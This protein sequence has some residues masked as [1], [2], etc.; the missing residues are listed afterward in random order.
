MQQSKPFGAWAS[1]ISAK[2][3]TSAGL[4]LGDVKSVDGAVFWAEVRP[5][6]K[7]RCVI[8]K[9]AAGQKPVD[10]FASPFNV[11][12]RVH[13]Y[14]GG[15][16][17]VDQQFLYFVHWDDQ[18]LYRVSHENQNEQPV[19]LTI[20]PET[21]Q[22]LRYADGCLSADGAWIVCVRE[23]HIDSQSHPNNELVAIPNATDVGN[24]SGDTGDSAII[25]AS[26]EDFY[27]TPRISPD[28]KRLSWI[29]WSHPQMPWDG[30]EL[31]V[32]DIHD[33]NELHDVSTS[34]KAVSGGAD[35]SVMGAM[36][37][38]N[39][40]LL[41]ASDESGWWN[42]YAY[43]VG[44]KPRQLTSFTDREVGTPAWVFGTQR[45]VLIGGQATQSSHRLALAVTHNARDE[46]MLL[47]ADEKL[48]KIELPYS[49]ISSIAADEHGALL[50]S[51]QPETKQASIMRIDIATDESCSDFKT[52]RSVE[53]LSIHADWIS[54]AQAITFPSS[55]K[56][57][58]AF[59]YPPTGH[60]VNGSDQE[61]PP[62][63]VMSHGGPTSHANSGLKL[64]VQYWTSRGIAVVDV[65]YGGSSGFGRDYRRRLQG[66]WSV[67]DVEDCI[68]AAN[69]LAEQ[70]MVDASRMVIRGGSAGGL[71]VLRAM[72]TSSSFAAGA[73]FYGVADLELLAG[74]THKFESRY[75]D[76]LL[77]GP[78][79]E[80]KSIYQERSP[81][82]HTDKLNCPILVM[83][84]DE[85]K[86]VPPNQ[87]ET[88]VNAAAEKGLPHAYIVFTGE[89]HGFRQPKNII[90]ALQI[91]LWFYSKVLGFNT[92]EKIAA[93]SE[94]IGL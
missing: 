61:L 11:R 86:V 78:Y 38:S 43:T 21:K 58:H 94:A 1:P 53:P 37:A 17:W 9:A 23:R 40:E 66:Q 42:V 85:D 26:G 2:L 80:C 46:L 54:V 83:Q 48:S 79:P 51:G 63:I 93:P 13:E 91:E 35:I 59:F 39:G 15:A 24:D 33:L 20:E 68:A 65:N 90:R 49:T 28:G 10:L 62:L 84:G 30:T 5:A 64:S 14:G 27:S 25:L 77:G 6:D 34:A 70:K 89:Q 41:F 12:T 87:S 45:F 18:R 3:V 4:K 72:Q 16:W 31:M 67:V 55:D 73:S 32:A 44:E 22:A 71:T 81:I 36:W 75:L 52:L 57:S 29:Q 74:D 56:E 60:Q 19:A 50:V 82:N 76:G 7:G 47:G 69:Y 88:I 92:A 8:V